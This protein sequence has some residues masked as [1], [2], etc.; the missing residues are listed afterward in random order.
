MRKIESVSGS[1]S[2]VIKAPSQWFKFTAPA[3]VTAT[4]CSRDSGVG[5]TLR[6][7][8]TTARGTWSRWKVSLCLLFVVNNASAFAWGSCPWLS[9]NALWSSYEGVSRSRSSLFHTIPRR[10]TILCVACVCRC[11]VC[12]RSTDRLF[13]PS[14]DSGSLYSSHFSQFSIDSEGSYTHYT[15]VYICTCLF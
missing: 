2:I 5:C 9:A 7:A 14:S 15:H 10:V 8:Q 12:S 3:S 4:T 11:S 6:R 1:H 13:P